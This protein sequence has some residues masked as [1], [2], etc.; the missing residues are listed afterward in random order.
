MR[1]LFRATLFT[2]ILIG[3]GFQAQ[4]QQPAQ[5]SLWQF[6]P[7]HFNPAYAGLDNSLS[8]TGIFRRQWVGLEGAPLTQNVNIHFPVEYMNSAFGL[9]LENDVLGAERNIT[10]TATYAY[11][12]QFGEGNMISAGLNGGILQKTID[13]TMLN[14]RDI[15]QNDNLIPQGIVRGIAPI[16]S[17]GVFFKNQ[18]IKAGVSA[19]N[20]LESSLPYTYTASAGIQLV[21]NYFA[22]FA[23]KFEIGD[24]GI[25]PAILFKSDLVEN[26]IDFSTTIF[27]QE[28][29]FGGA[30]YRGFS[31]N[32]S[33][34]VAIFAGY[35]VNENVSFAYAYDVP[36][37]TLS[38]VN[39][40]SHEIMLNYNLNKTIG[41]PL[42]AKIIYNPRFTF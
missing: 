36:I 17:A 13:G 22:I 26:Q 42:P 35:R 1:N 7:H 11:Q 10:A 20:L 37:S 27:Y 6:N 4:A 2:I 31:V 29:L 40:G 34:A 8:V 14:P 18:N 9:K 23:Y 32:T 5:Y 30:A 3:L 16:F 12:L 15:D 19:N 41:T 39:T 38:S 25:E 21:R 33:D 24:F 28:K